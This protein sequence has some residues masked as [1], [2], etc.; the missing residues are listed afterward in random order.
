[1]SSAA[2]GTPLTVDQAAGGNLLLSFQDLGGAVGLYN[3]YEGTLGG[4]YNHV[5]KACGAAVSAANGRLQATITPV[6]GNTYY[7]VT[8][9][10]LCQEG[11]SGSDS[12]GTPQPAANL[13]CSP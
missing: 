9:A 8:A 13:T 2:S 7:L 12:S 6:A 1:V 11:T 5:P 4:G 3:I 10:D